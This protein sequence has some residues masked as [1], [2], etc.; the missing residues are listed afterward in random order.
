MKLTRFTDV[1]WACD[2]DDRKS[3]GAYCIYLGKNLISLSSKKQSVIVRS[4]LEG[5]YRALTS[6]SAEISWLQ[7]LFSNIRVCCVETPIIWH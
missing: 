4:S 1:D 5:E 6:T 7:S 2:L 3:V